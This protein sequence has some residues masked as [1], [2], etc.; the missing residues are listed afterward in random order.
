[1]KDIDG[2]AVCAETKVPHFNAVGAG[3]EDVLSLQVPVHNIII[4]LGKGEK[5]RV[6]DKDCFTYIVFC[7]TLNAKSQAKLYS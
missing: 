1:M 4:M 5:R 6:K 7:Y 2:T 3:V